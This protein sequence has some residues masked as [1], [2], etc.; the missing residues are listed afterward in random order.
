MKCP[1]Y[2]SIV[3]SLLFASF[4]SVSLTIYS[5]SFKPPFSDDTYRCRC[6]PE[7]LYKS[8]AIDESFGFHWKECE[9]ATYA[10]QIKPH[11][12]Y[13]KDILCQNQES[14]SKWFWDKCVR[15]KEKI[16]SKLD[17]YLN[18]DDKVAG[19]AQKNTILDLRNR[20]YNEIRGLPIKS[21]VTI[22]DFKQSLANCAMSRKKTKKLVSWFVESL[23]FFGT[24][25]TVSDEA[26][27]QDIINLMPLKEIIFQVHSSKIRD[28]LVVLLERNDASALFEC[29]NVLEGFCNADSQFPRQA[30]SLFFKDELENH[31]LLSQAS[32]SNNRE[33]EICCAFI[34]FKEYINV[35][36]TLHQSLGSSAI[37]NM[38]DLYDLQE[39]KMIPESNYFS[40]TLFSVVDDVVAV[41]SIVSSMPIN[42]TV[43][44]LNSLAG[45]LQKTLHKLRAHQKGRSESWFQEMWVKVPVAIGVVVIK[46]FE[47]YCSINVE[48][49]EKDSLFTKPNIKPSFTQFDELVPPSLL[50]SGKQ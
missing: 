43:D 3:V 33:K 47:H 18:E 14:L 17:V 36:T 4:V 28:A 42:D 12:L 20:L 49:E 10:T 24:G 22:D 25:N 34:L 37:K 6:L 38:N 21:L 13:L 39:K 7:H 27:S 44:A 32:F 35:L 11:T 23:W 9:L 30:F 15:L 8:E 48:K 41:Y 50:F 19:I 5:H 40:R 26:V 31:P 1:A 16:I 2:K 45:S 46:V 29:W